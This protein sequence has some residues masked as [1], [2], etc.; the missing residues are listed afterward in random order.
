MSAFQ[1]AAAW[2]PTASAVA[3]DAPFP[4]AGPH[5]PGSPAACAIQAPAGYRSVAAR[6]DRPTVPL[7]ISASVRRWLAVVRQ[8]PAGCAGPPDVVAAGLP[9]APGWRRMDRHRAR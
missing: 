3:A 1:P 4:D 2:S 7:R 8:P 6:L 5:R 9:A